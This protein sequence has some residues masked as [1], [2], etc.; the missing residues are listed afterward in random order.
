M[1]SPRRDEILQLQGQEMLTMPANP[2]EPRRATPQFSEG[3][4]SSVH[5]DFRLLSPDFQ[6]LEFSCF[7]C[8]I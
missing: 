3:A 5:L 4:W 6:T 2:K 1:L 8:F 7:C